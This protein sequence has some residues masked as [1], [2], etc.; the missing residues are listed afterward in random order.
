MI[1]ERTTQLSQICQGKHVDLI[2]SGYNETVLPYGWFALVSGI[3]GFDVPLEE[4]VP[5]PERLR[6]DLA[7]EATKSVITQVK[8]NL[9]DYWR[10]FQ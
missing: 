1:G 3:A 6:E 4:P 2:A 8:S 10:C 5:I 7:L 9:K